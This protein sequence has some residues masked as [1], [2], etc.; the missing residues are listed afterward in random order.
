MGKKPLRPTDVQLYKLLHRC[1]IVMQRT[2]GAWHNGESKNR[3]D[4]L[5]AAH[6]VEKLLRHFTLPPADDEDGGTA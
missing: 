3:R 2:G 6:A 4:L 5:S 1:M